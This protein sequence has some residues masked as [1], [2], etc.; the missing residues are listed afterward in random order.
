[1]ISPVGALSNKLNDWNPD[2]LYFF[3]NLAPSSRSDGAGIVEAA[4]NRVLKLFPQL[5]EL[6]L[7]VCKATQFESPAV[8][9]LEGDFTPQLNSKLT[10]L[11]LTTDHAKTVRGGLSD[12]K[13]ALAVIAAAA[14]SAIAVPDPNAGAVVRAASTGPNR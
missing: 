4:V 12:N 11:Q 3:W 6:T 1:M 10:R 13:K 5:K 14:A 8:L 7:F 9:K 2:A